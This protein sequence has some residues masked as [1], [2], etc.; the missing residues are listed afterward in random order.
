MVEDLRAVGYAGGRA[1]RLLGAALRT[2]ATQGGALRTLELTLN[3]TVMA[4]LRF[5]NGSRCAAAL[6]NS[7]RVEGGHGG[8]GE[9]AGWVSAWEAVRSWAAVVGEVSAQLQCYN[10]LDLHQIRADTL[11]VLD[12]SRRLLGGDGGLVIASLL[13]PLR[14]LRTLVLHRCLLPEPATTAILEA[15]RPPPLRPPPGPSLGQAAQTVLSRG[16]PGCL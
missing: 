16:R 8:G 6:P 1:L 9:P 7:A 15:L 14:T 10:G 3:P 13:P 11:V 2:N 12:L 5:R 4:Q